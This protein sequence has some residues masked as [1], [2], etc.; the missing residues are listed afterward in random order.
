MLQVQGLKCFPGKASAT[1]YL[2]GLASLEDFVL[3]AF[4]KM[5]SHLG[6]EMEVML[7]LLLKMLGEKRV[8][9][10]SPLPPKGP[11]EFHL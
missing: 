3:G 1:Q 2:T 6:V 7:H 10:T 4:P 11:S 9:N 8:G 5:I